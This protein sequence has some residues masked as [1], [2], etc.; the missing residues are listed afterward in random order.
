VPG[1]NNFVGDV[2]RTAASGV[3]DRVFADGYNAAANISVDLLSQKIDGLHGQVR[4]GQSLSEKDQFLLSSLDAMRS[5]L[6][7]AL[8]GYWE[9]SDTE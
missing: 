7:A 5:E 1:L 3:V 8:R 4:A 9:G 2:L 6:D